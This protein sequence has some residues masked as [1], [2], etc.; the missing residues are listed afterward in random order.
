L[1]QTAVPSDIPHRQRGKRARDPV[2]WS[3]FGPI[4]SLRGGLLAMTIL[5]I[6]PLVLF[7]SGMALV[8]AH[9]TQ[10]LVTAAAWV[11]VAAL[12][13]LIGVAAV[14][15]VSIA[16]EALV[17][18]WLGY[19]ERL[20]R[21][22]ARGRYSV[23]PI[24]LQKAPA[25]FRA[26]GEVVAAMA[27][28]VEHRDQALRNALDEQTV[29]LR[30]VHHRVKNNL[31]IVGSLL[32]LQ[33]AR[34]DDPAV[35]AALQDALVRIDAMSLS[36]RFMQQQEEEEQVASVELFETF[37]SQARARLGA[38]RRNVDFVLD[39][40][41]F[42]MP[43]ETGSRLV[44]VAVEALLCAFRSST[45]PMQFTLT[46]R[47]EP[48]GVMLRLAAPGHPDIFVNG[49]RVSRDLIDGYVRQ[50][51]GRLEVAKGSATLVV[52]APL[53]LML[54]PAITTDDAAA[55]TQGLRFFRVLDRTH[56]SVAS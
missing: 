44:M 48:D 9:D 40:E 7:A 28:G 19:L 14:L 15:I 13:V 20:S 35:K 10:R 47:Q 2:A 23:R 55:P 3:G 53:S 43:L 11:T 41:P 25:E 45:G 17:M 12:P 24:R 5:A 1:N 36:Q 49:E 22:Y 6:T 56:G 8:Q 51:R 18:Q 46:V 54:A 50:L 52:R 4:K 32:S 42:V 37:L 29:L 39:V 27:S 26:L 31:Q 16:I 33:A 34:S 21:A 38:S 30:E